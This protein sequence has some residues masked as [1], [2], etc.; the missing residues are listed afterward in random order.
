MLADS[1]Q[2]CDFLHRK[3]EAEMPVDR[4]HRFESRMALAVEVGN[5]GDEILNNIILGDD[6]LRPIERA[7]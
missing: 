4:P 6:Q 7:A 2:V 5:A 3:T 1:Q